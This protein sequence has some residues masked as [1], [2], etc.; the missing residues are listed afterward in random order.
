VRERVRERIMG[1]GKRVSIA[2]SVLGPKPAALQVSPPATTTTAALAVVVTVLASRDCFL[3][4]GLGP[5]VVW[6][7]GA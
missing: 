5:S 6:L 3:E 2:S 1:A 7:A 4:L